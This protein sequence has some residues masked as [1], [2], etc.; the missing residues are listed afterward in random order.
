MNKKTLI[1]K[2]LHKTFNMYHKN[3]ANK[4]KW[5]KLWRSRDNSDLMNWKVFSNLMNWLI[6]K[7]PI[8]ESYI[9]SLYNEWKDI[10]RLYSLFFTSK[11]K[12][13]WDSIALANTRYN[14]RDSINFSTERN[15]NSITEKLEWKII[16]SIFSK[17]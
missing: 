14:C 11:N 3:K 12:Q 15:H 9:N 10:S 7:E 1:E 5:I 13:Y 8:I 2:W 6:K 17:Q 16:G 4:L